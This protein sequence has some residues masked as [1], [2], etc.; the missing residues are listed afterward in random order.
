[1]VRP[2]ALENNCPVM[3]RVGDLQIDQDLAFERRAWRAQYICQG[4]LVLLVA[5]ALAGLFGS[6]PLEHATAADAS[7]GLRVEYPRF[8][9][10]LADWEVVLH[11]APELARGG[12]FEIWFDRSLGEQ[13]KTDAVLPEPVEMSADGERIVARFRAA[14]D[15]AP[16]RIVWVVQA[17][18]PGQGQTRLGVV[19]GPEVELRYFI[20][21]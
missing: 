20:Y 13:F 21:P 2:R 8:A 4:L 10:R 16:S 19:G 9:R 12:Q 5:A 6:G 14:E 11:I 7:G 1:M 17:R 3:K 18:H 15:P